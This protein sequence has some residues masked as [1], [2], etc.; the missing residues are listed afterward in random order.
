LGLVLISLQEER[1]FKMARNDKTA[2]TGSSEEKQV[3]KEAVKDEEKKEKKKTMK[4]R[5]FEVL[6]WLA[7]ILGWQR[8]SLQ[9]L[10]ATKATG[11]PGTV[12]IGDKQMPMWMLSIV[13]RVSKEDEEQETVILHSTN[14][15][16][17]WQKKYFEF[18]DVLEKHG[19]DT[20]KLRLMLIRIY[21]NKDAVGKNIIEQ[22]VQADGDLSEQ[23][24]IAKDNY[25]LERLGFLIGIGIWF[26]DHKIIANLMALPIFLLLTINALCFLY[27]GITIVYFFLYGIFLVIS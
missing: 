8:F 9:E 27:W 22:I 15:S 12:Q 23:M 19:Y 25:L 6:Q 18:R 10:A 20:T 3:V 1:E 17:N 5:F 26:H 4:D 24:S 11:Q 13:A 16:R 21:K 7:I 2:K 14:L